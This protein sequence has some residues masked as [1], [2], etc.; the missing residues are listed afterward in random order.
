MAKMKKGSAAAKAWGRKMKALR[1]KPKRKKSTRK[2][3]I[4]K[5]ARRA[6]TKVKRKTNKVKRRRKSVKGL[7]S[8]TGS[9]TLKKVA[10]GVGGAAIATAVI[11]MIMPNSAIARYAGPIGGY[12]MGGIEGVLGAMVLPMVSGRVGGN[13]NV[14]PAMEV[15]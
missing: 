3:G 5:T 10:L 2:G 7:K 8:I 11:S 4:R 6:Y 15:L 12:A 9:S 1:N 14:A 13:A